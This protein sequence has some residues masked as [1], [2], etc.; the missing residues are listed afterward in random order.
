M[1]ALRRAFDEGF[2][3]PATAGTALQVD[4]LA[5]GVAEQNL[6]VRLDEVGRIARL[7]KRVPVP[8][9]RPQLLGL[10]AIQD[11]LLALFSLAALLGQ[12]GSE[13]EPWLLLPAGDQPV[14]LAFDRFDGL[15]R[16]GQAA[17][18]RGD[19]AEGDRSLAGG[20]VRVGDLV[21]G[22][23]DLRAVLEEIGRSSGGAG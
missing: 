3:A 15:V 17:L 13:A 11:R 19:G 16:V 2:S 7:R 22:V 10:V 9:A 6:I 5:I 23:L 14:A 20:L 8:G 4:M 12:R 18:A 1:L 21:R